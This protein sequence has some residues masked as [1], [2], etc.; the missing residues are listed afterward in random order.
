MGKGIEKFKVRRKRRMR[1]K[2]VEVKRGKNRR[3]E[4]EEIVDKQWEK[5]KKI[6]RK[7]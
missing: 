5:G 1:S 3:M 7:K 2:G 6:I 4:K